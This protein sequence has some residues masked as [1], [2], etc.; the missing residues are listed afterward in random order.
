[1]NI[2]EAKKILF[3]NNQ[4]ISTEEEFIKDNIDSKIKYYSPQHILTLKAFYDIAKPNIG[5][6][7]F[8][9]ISFED[10][11][12]KTKLSDVV[13]NVCYNDLTR[14]GFLIMTHNIYLYHYTTR[15]GI[16][17]IEKLL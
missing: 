2:E 7:V 13:L 10:I 1:V 6:N 12:N 4:D 17:L 11:K 5:K 8:T 9:N 3:D 14:D 16:I 15:L